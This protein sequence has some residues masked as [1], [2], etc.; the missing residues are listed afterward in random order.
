MLPKQG[1]GVP[2]PVR[3]LDTTRRNL[4]RKLQLKILLA[5]QRWNS[6]RAAIKAE[7]NQ[8]NKH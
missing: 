3:E 5:Q 1:A 2:A 8:I 6:P 4:I 7:R